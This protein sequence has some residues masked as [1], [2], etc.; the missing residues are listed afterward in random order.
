M[1]LENRDRSFLV[2]LV[3]I[4]EPGIQLH[5]SLLHTSET[6]EGDSI[7]A[8]SSSGSDLGLGNWRWE[9]VRKWEVKEVCGL[10]VMG[11]QCLK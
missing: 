3:P 10:V 4:S 1:V 11:K 5:R 6:R 2:S 7:Q 9:W 8:L